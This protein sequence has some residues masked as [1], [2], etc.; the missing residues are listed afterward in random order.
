MRN[1]YLEQKEKSAAFATIFIFISTFLKT[2]KTQHTKKSP[3]ILLKK[4]PF[5]FCK[6]QAPRTQNTTCKSDLL[7]NAASF[8]NFFEEKSMIYSVPQNCN[9]LKSWFTP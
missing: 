9:A 6:M 2:N 8:F 3:N 7:S 4:G 5:F 1:S